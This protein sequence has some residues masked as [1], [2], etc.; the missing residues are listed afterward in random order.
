MVKIVISLLI[1]SNA[2]V[3]IAQEK[4][5][6]KIASK[7]AIL[8]DQE[9]CYLEFF[10]RKAIVEEPFV[11]TLFG[12]KPMTL[13]L[14]TK[15]DELN[16][17]S[18]Y[19]KNQRYILSIFPL[20]DMNNVRFCKGLEVW[21]KYQHLF[22][23]SNF[24]FLESRDPSRREIGYLFLINKK[25]FLKAIESNLEDFKKILGSGITSRC[26][27]REIQN[28]KDVFKSLKHSNLLIGI[29]FG[30]GRH[31]ADLFQKK[32]EFVKRYPNKRTNCP[33]KLQPF[34]T[35]GLPLNSLMLNL[36]C[37]AADWKHPE[38]KQL[39]QK[40]HSQRQEVL[41]QYQSGD[42]LETTLQQLC[43]IR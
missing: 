20:V 2:L 38:T 33:F 25:A 1:L 5:H 30:Y 34:N 19:Q 10:F 17:L 23:L 6:Q 28:T 11:Y 18:V 32:Y 14:F 29:L 13:I 8:S 12:D 21:K 27:L 9:R 31:N 16:A 35:S 41:K 39:S 26:L 37:F 36:P 43:H 24:I 4:N 22:P 40:Y 3:Q 42:F 15:K 7:L